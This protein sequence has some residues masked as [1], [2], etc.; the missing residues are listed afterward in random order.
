MSLQ[1]SNAFSFQSCSFECVSFQCVV[2]PRPS[3]W[4]WNVTLQIYIQGKWP[5][6]PKPTTTWQPWFYLVL[7]WEHMSW[8]PW[9]YFETCFLSFSYLQ[10]I[11]WTVDFRILDMAIA[12]RM[13]FVIA[14]ELVEY[15]SGFKALWG[16]CNNSTTSNNERQ[17]VRHDARWI[18]HCSAQVH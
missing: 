5:P 1:G 9:F 2:L 12:L 3:P 11:I 17:T 15:C 18:L 4:N 10:M 13:Q 16:N 14:G 8:T 7:F 6:K